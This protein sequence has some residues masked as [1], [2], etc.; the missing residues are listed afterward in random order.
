MDARS[1]ARS[2]LSDPRVL[3][4]AVGALL[5]ANLRYWPTVAGSTNAQLRRW[6]SRAEE[7]EDPRLHALAVAKLR[8]E[9]FN[10]QVASTLATIVRRPLRPAAIEAIVALEV[11]FDHLDGLSE[12]LGG[13]PLGEALAILAP[14]REAVEVGSEGDRVAARTDRVPARTDGVATVADRIATPADDGVGMQAD[15]GYVAELVRAVRDAIAPLPALASVQRSL[16]AAAQRCIE[17]QAHMHAASAI[18]EGPVREWAI[19]A[20]EGG[21]LNWREHLAGAASSVL[22]M[23]ALIAAAADPCTTERDALALDELYLCIGVMSTTLD[24]VVDREQDIESG[25]ASQAA[26]YGDP[27]EL[28]EA[29]V[30]VCE[31]I[32]TR[33]ADAPHAAHHL[34]SL[35]GVLAYYLSSPRASDPFAAAVTEQLRGPLR[36]LLAAPMLVMRAWRLGKALPGR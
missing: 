28:S 17:A 27:R 7:I 12:E 24:S 29:L 20:A 4:R 30:S 1:P 35:S 8:D 36:P 31:Q 13:D 22:A 21:P 11:L 2:Q 16:L 26:R 32:V 19:R 33:S 3:T 15:G 14:V 9:H 34:M 5:L 23:H 6:R 18:G 25:A 10:A